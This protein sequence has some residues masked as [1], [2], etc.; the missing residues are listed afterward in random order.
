MGKFKLRTIGFLTITA[1]LLTPLMVF[2]IQDQHNLNK[3]IPWQNSSLDKELIKKY[4][5]IND[6]YTEFFTNITFQ[7]N[8]A[9]YV[10]RNKDNYSADQQAKITAL[11]ELFKQEVDLL[12][13]QEVIDYNLLELSSRDAYQVD[14]GTIYDKSLD[15]QGIYLLDQL[16]RF[17]TD[18]DNYANFVMNA[19]SKKIT[20]LS[21]TNHSLAKLKKDDLKKMG[22][23]MIEYLGLAKIDDWNYTDYGYE[24][25]QAKLQIVCEVLEFSGRY[26]LEIRVS[27][28]GSSRN[29]IVN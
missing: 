28:L 8:A 3:K 5:I 26:T 17:N 4:P 12:L 22:W 10:I 27:M 7:D 29:I 25:Y 11:Q 9:R 23:Q 1:L 16:Y 14:F 6:I 21:L 24:S 15:D 18:N 13:K 2:K 20:S 19:K